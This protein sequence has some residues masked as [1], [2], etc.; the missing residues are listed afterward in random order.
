MTLRQAQG[1]RILIK[2]LTPLSL[3]LSKAARHLGAGA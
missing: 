2:L 1:E 3:S